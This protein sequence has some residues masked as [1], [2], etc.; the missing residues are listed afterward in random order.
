MLIMDRMLG[1][2]A[3]TSIGSASIG[4]LALKRNAVLSQY[5]NEVS[6]VMYIIGALMV[7]AIALLVCGKYLHGNEWIRRMFGRVL[8]TG[9]FYYLVDGF[10]SLLRKRTIL[11]W[12]FLISMAVQ[13][14]AL[15]GLLTLAYTMDV[16]VV[17]P[18]SLLAVAAVV[19]LIGIIPV[20]PG[21][22]GWTELV[23]AFAW[24]IVGSHSGAAIFLYWRIVTVICSLPG[25]V[26]YLIHSSMPSQEAGTAARP[27]SP[28]PLSE[29]A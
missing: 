19:I 3:I 8:G 26:I 28:P 2:V 5:H 13:I 22:I 27:V 21:N 20:T 1:V 6:L 11:F 24:S 7:L 25:G 23:A 12:A 29:G 4:Y 14:L 18:V 17:N 16:T 15:S 10:G 9:F